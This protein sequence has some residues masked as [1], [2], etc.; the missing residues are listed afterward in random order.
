MS[1]FSSEIWNSCVC[2]DSE[3]TKETYKIYEISFFSYEISSA[4]LITHGSV[5]CKASRFMCLVPIYEPKKIEYSVS[6][7]LV[8]GK[9]GTWLFFFLMG[10]DY[11]FLPLILFVI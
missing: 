10:N 5:K 4:F 3:K 11:L 7:L 2:L 1:V 9:I 8:A 6:F